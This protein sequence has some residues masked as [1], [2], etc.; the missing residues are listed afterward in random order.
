[1]LSSKRNAATSGFLASDTVLNL[2]SC[3][4][5]SG[6]LLSKVLCKTVAFKET[7]CEADE[8]QSQDSLDGSLL[9]SQDPMSDRSQS[10]ACSGA[11]EGEREEQ[12]GRWESEVARK[13]GN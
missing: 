1:M 7:K 12:R 2:L 11:R 4:F 5:M 3:D 13:W 10:D 6:V 8:R 9:H